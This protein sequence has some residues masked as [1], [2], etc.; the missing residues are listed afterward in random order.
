[1]SIP[2]LFL[3]ILLYLRATMLAAVAG[4]AAFICVLSVGKVKPAGDRGFTAAVAAR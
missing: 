1:M 3:L 4:S 2:E